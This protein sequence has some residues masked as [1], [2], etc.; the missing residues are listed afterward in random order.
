[1]L[2]FEGPEKM[3]PEHCLLSDFLVSGNNIELRCANGSTAFFHSR[4]AEGDS[5]IANIAGKLS[6]CVG[7]SYQS[8]LETE[9]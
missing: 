5:E 7:K 6:G 3:D 8:I 9:F 4:N 2:H 1:M